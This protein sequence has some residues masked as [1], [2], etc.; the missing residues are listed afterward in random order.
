MR[1]NNAMNRGKHL[2]GV[3]VLGAWMAATASAGEIR[4]IA[5]PGIPLSAISAD[6][7]QH[8]FLETKVK[9]P[10][11]TRVEPV[12]QSG[13]PAHNEIL[14]RFLGKTD[15]AL[16]TYYRSLVFTG[17]G[18]IPKTLDS[19]AAVAAYVARTKGAI[20]YVRADTSTPGCKTLEVK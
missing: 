2:V 20:G 1:I 18:L 16:I 13:G 19:D 5:N 10:D 7:V 14:R 8:F 12:L 4:I 9:L 11:G 6:E 15:T 17:R 3:A